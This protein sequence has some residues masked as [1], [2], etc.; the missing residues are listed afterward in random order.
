MWWHQSWTLCCNFMNNL[1]SSYYNN[2]Y[3]YSRP[4]YRVSPKNLY[5]L[6]WLP[7][8]NVWFWGKRFRI[9]YGFNFL[10]TSKSQKIIHAWVSTAHCLKISSRHL[11][12]NFVSSKGLTHVYLSQIGSQI[13][14][15]NLIFIPFTKKSSVPPIMNFFRLFCHIWK[16]NS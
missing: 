8:K 13:L 15:R 12:V 9:A 11:G 10:M 16:L 5:T 2:L 7:N 6:K 4:M 1:M 14:L 3:M